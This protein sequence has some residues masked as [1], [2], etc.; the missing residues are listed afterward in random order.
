MPAEGFMIRTGKF[1][2]ILASEVLSI[3]PPNTPELLPSPSPST[4]L[5]RAQE[6]SASSP[7]DGIEPRRPGSKSGGSCGYFR[8]ESAD[9]IFP[10]QVP[11]STIHFQV[12]SSNLNSRAHSMREIPA[13]ASVPES[14]HKLVPTSEFS[15]EP[16]PAPTFSDKSIPAPESAPTHEPAPESEPSP[17]TSKASAPHL[18][19]TQR[20]KQR[21]KKRPSASPAPEHSPELAP[22]P[23]FSLIPDFSHESAPA[24]EFSNESAP[25]S[26]FCNEPVQTP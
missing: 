5:M 2:A 18:T 12:R 10:S 20:R 26:E 3:E 22:V 13:S 17:R 19:S 15:P 7:E 11:T 25:A 16:A 6:S 8:L 14:S 9:D 23:E 21:K 1:C 24:P 4:L